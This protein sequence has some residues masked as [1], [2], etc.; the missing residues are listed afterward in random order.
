MAE[1]Y[2]SIWITTVCYNHSCA[3]GHLGCFFL[4]SVLDNAAVNMCVCE[5]L[6]FFS[7]RFQFCGDL[8]R[9]GIAGIIW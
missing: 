7:I 4:L 6:G 3:D 2:S 5:L 8:P 1:L 9:S